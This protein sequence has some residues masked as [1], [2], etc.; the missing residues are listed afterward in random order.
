MSAPHPAIQENAGEHCLQ[1][2]VSLEWELTSAISAIAGNALEP[3]EK[4]LW[5]QQV[6]CTGL[7]HLVQTLQTAPVDPSLMDAVRSSMSALHSLNQTYAELVRQ[8]R[9]QSQVLHALCDTYQQSQPRQAAGSRA[10]S[11]EV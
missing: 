10:C 2:L 9:S 1:H 7:K 4:S 3:L 6:L 5:N 8:A 11:L